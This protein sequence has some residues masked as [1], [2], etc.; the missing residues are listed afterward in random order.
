MS[1]QKNELRQIITDALVS[2]VSGVTGLVPP[3]G[4]GAIPD[5]IQ[6]PIDRAV[7][8]ISASLPVGVTD[9]WRD[10]LQKIAKHAPPVNC[11]AKTEVEKLA[12]IAV[13][14]LITFSA[15][16]F[17]KP[18]DHQSAKVGTAAP[19]V[20]PSFADD[21]RKPHE[22]S[23]EGCRCVRFGEGNPHWPCPIHAAPTVKAEQVHDFDVFW[24]SELREELRKSCARGWA[25][26]IWKA[27]TA[28]ARFNFAYDASLPAA[29]SAVQ[30][31]A[32]RA[33]DQ[34]VRVAIKM[35]ERTLS[36]TAMEIA[37]ELRRCLGDAQDALSAQQSA[38]V[39]VPRE[40]IQIALDSV[41]NAMEDAYNNAYQNCCGRGNG[42]C[43]GDPEPAWSD[44]DHA[45]MDALAPAQRELRALLNGGEA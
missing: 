38:H 45:I 39:S 31:K 37:A 20:K 43:C 22:L 33:Y 36:P 27:A 8:K 23:A 29:G 15:P 9:A 11:A 41:Q 18:T 10:A 25:E 7:E 35:L 16:Q 24:N 14:A 30:A 17:S 21:P 1:E 5:F 42:Q 13:H 12:L 34:P 2:I 3:S 26:L 6:A 44:A 4:P 19:T 28:A 40:R 32:L